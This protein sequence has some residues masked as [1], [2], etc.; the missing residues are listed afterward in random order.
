M[1]NNSKLT[2]SNSHMNHSGEPNSEGTKA[3]VWVRLNRLEAQQ[4]QQQQNADRRYAKVKAQVDSMQLQLSSLALATREAVQNASRKYP[5]DGWLLGSITLNFI[6]LFA[7]F[8]L[9]S[10]VR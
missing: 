4:Q 2:L 10:K 6:L 5:Q 3:D 9:R 7:L 8:V 1:M